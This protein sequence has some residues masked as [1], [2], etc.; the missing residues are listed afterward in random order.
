MRSER[1]FFSENVSQ[2]LS[3]NE[4]HSEISWLSTTFLAELLLNYDTIYTG[5][6]LLD[7]L[8]ALVTCRNLRYFDA[9]HP[10]DIRNFINIFG[11]LY[12]VQLGLESRS[13]KGL[14]TPTFVVL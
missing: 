5:N 6:I 10:S 7:N 12:L 11:Q 14:K 1:E 2:G 13:L 3:I 4:K 9:S 8:V